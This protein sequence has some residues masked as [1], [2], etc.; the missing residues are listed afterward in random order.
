MDGGSD[1]FPL[2]L[3]TTLFVES[4]WLW[5]L[6]FDCSSLHYWL[7]KLTK[8]LLAFSSYNFSIQFWKH[9]EKQEVGRKW[10]QGLFRTFCGCCVTCYLK[11]EHS[12]K[13][14][15]NLEVDPFGKGHVKIFRNHLQ[16]QYPYQKSKDILFLPTWCQSKDS[17]PAVQFESAFPPRNS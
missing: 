16:V 15:S 9:D 4:G 12:W 5:R 11:M 13:W 2:T 8:C 3:L 14:Q 1:W 17:L 7:W 10:S 6:I